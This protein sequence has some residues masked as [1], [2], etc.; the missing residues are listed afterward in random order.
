MI[1]EIGIEP[2]ISARLKAA[3][4]REVLAAVVTYPTPEALAQALGVEPRR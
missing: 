4:A 1:G 2:V 3:R